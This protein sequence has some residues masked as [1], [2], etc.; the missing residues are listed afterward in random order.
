MRIL[1]LAC[2]YAAA[3]FAQ[4]GSAAGILDRLEARP[5]QVAAADI[6]VLTRALQTDL[7]GGGTIG[8]QH[9]LLIGR[10]SN[11]LSQLQTRNDLDPSVG[12]AAAGAWQRLAM[13]MDAPDGGVAADSSGALLG[14]RNA[15]L[16][17][18]RYGAQSGQLG[19]LGGRI[20]ALGGSMPG[21]ISIGV[22]P[23][24]ESQSQNEW[25]GMPLR[26]SANA[27]SGPLAQLPP[28]PK[29][30]ASTLPPESAKQ[31]RLIEERYTSVAASVYTARS[32][33]EAIRLSVQSRGL[34]L[35]PDTEQ[36]LVR[37][38][39]SMNMALKSIEALRFDEGRGHLD[40]AAEYAS[41]LL[42]IAG[43]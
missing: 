6:G 33:T 42:K 38:D 26:P 43:R 16:L 31:Y 27:P 19:Y 28:F 22:N 24:Q 18:S 15:Y 1:F 41:R 3:C 2:F 13:A 39:I 25:G 21:W 5:T 23:Q 30:D 12:I 14:Y 29:L 17:Y 32:S 35:H 10:T 7:G 36:M 20:R 37:M 4:E 9:R 11:Y 8:P 40:A 34:A